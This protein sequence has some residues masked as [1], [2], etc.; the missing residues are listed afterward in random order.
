[1]IS[2]T[3]DDT[4]SFIVNNKVITPNE[5]EINKNPR[6]RSAKLRIAKRNE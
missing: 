3:D 5:N 2:F 4:E 1:M 6:S